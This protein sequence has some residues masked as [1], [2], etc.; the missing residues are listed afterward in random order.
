MLLLLLILVA[1]ASIAALS[2]DVSQ[3]GGIHTIAGNGQGGPGG[4]KIRLQ[5]SYPTSKWGVSL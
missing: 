1:C 2:S 4:V 3:F 5:Y